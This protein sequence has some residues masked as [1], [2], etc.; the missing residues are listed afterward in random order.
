MRINDTR[1]PVVNVGN[2]ENPTYLPLQVCYV[3]PGQPS[4]SK[5]DPNQTQQM[6][7]FAVRRP[8]ENATSIVNQ[9]LQTAGLSASTNPLLVRLDHSTLFCSVKKN[10]LL[11]SLSLNLE[12]KSPK[13]S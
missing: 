13:I 10:S 4:K 9:G 6:I 11:I 7:R 12:L 3:L 2:R 5:L 1:L 8:F